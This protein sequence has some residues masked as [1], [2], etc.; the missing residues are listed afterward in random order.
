[1]SILRSRHTLMIVL[2]LTLAL[3][4]LL[5]AQAATRSG[6]SFRLD[7]T[8]FV[9]RGGGLSLDRDNTGSGL[10]TITLSAVDGAGNVI[11]PGVSSTAFVG[12]TLVL[13]DGLRWSWA[14]T[15]AANPLILTVT[16]AAGNGLEAEVVYQAAG[17]CSGLPTTEA[18]ADLLALPDG[19]TSPS[20]PINSVA[21]RPDGNDDV[22]GSQDGWS[23]MW[24]TAEPAQRDDARYTVGGDYRWRHP[25]WWRWAKTVTEAGGACRPTKFAA[26]LAMIWWSF[27]AICPTC[28]WSR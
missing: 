8:G 20:V 1:M 5:P 7:C 27:A 4:T 17:L 16:S 2:L 15:P 19:I 23:S 28:R 9:S 3:L 13:Q 11:L 24:I 21:P 12:S 18:G 10:E 22:A 26:G 25:H 14:N 6:L